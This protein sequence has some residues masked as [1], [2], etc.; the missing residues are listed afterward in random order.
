MN[1]MGRRE[2]V[3]VSMGVRTVR[4]MFVFAV[5]TLLLVGPALLAGADDGAVT[6]QSVTA[7][8]EESPYT[9][10]DF[11]SVDA[12]SW[13]Q[14]FEPLARLPLWGQAAVLS[15]GVAGLFFVVPMVF[16]WVWNL[17]DEGPDGSGGPAT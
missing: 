11:D 5:L 2:G 4:F 7:Q 10:P 9:P 12:P 6:H 16:K 3:G 1:D 14:P 17:G 8:V 13:L 15:A